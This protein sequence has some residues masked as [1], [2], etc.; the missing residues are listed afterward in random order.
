MQARLLKLFARLETLSL[1]EQAMIVL[2]I[3]AVLVLVGEML[4]FSP[5]RARAAEAQKVAALKQ[6][7]LKALSATLVA[8]PPPGQ[9]PAADQ[10]R[11]QRAELQVQIAEGRTV[12]AGTS[13]TVD[14]GTVVRATVSGTPGLALA[15]LRTQPAEV[16]FTPAMLKPVAA[17]GK[18]GAPASTPTAA[19]APATGTEAFTVYRH[20][21]E[22]TVKGN[23]GTLLGYLQTLQQAPTGEGALYALVD[24]VPPEWQT[25]CRLAGI[26]AGAGPD[27]AKLSPDGYE[28]MLAEVARQFP[29]IRVAA[30]TLRTARSASVNGWGALAWAGGRIH[31][32]VERPDLEILDRVGGGDS[33]VAGLVYGL[34]EKNDLAAAVEYG[35]AHGAL[36]MTTPGD[37]SMATLAEVEQLVKGGS[38]RIRR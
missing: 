23:F 14:W 20:R 15:S 38:A 36:A 35:A 32:A 18:P 21:A 13:R 34:L 4:V 5:A 2:G 24:D 11:Q 33:F 25:L 27:V 28:A 30:A 29:G 17:G 26:L 6:N 7:E 3:P 37:T 22:M 12:M 9:L 31:R 8:L 10:L 1:R 16:I 19:S